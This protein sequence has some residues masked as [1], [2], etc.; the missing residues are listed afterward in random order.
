MTGDDAIFGDAGDDNIVGG[1]GNDWISG[2]AGSDGILG[3]DGRIYTS[4]NG[5]AETLFGIDASIEQT[6]EVK[7]FLETTIN[8]TG[9]LTKSV[10]L[11]PFDQG[12]N[13][14]I[15]GGQGDD[16]LHGGAGDDAMS[17][18]EALELYYGAHQTHED[19][20]GFNPETE[21]F[22][23]YN[24]NDPLS[25]I[26]VDD[27]GVFTTDGS[28]EE[29]LL[30]FETGDDGQDRLFGGDG[31]DWLVGG[32]NVDH[33]YGG[34]GS[35]LLNADDDLSTNGDANNL[36]DDADDG[37]SNADIAFGGGGRDV[38]IGNTQS[39][40]LIDWNGEFNSYV[41]PFSPFGLETISRDPR[42]SLVQYLYDL[43]RADGADA[44]RAADSGSDGSR[45]G[46]PD[47]ELGVVL[48]Q[49]DQWGQQKGKPA[50]PQ[51]GNGP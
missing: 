43:S 8:E 2:G 40:R 47:G 25:K 26:L 23:A 7:K 37:L 29:F 11:T 4:R 28:G 21:E 15:Y 24:E 10:N 6:I 12:G 14:I 5:T 19:V 13:D 9:S 17:G 39:D 50:D 27:M 16:F 41:V 49:D 34:M 22:K 51:P 31:N 45:N 35:D 38:L 42:P 36:P 32:G 30:N 20:L 44:T 1:S 33:L 18:A 3:D 48:Q 46:E